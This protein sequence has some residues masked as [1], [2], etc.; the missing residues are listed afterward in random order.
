MP[1]FSAPNATPDPAIWR[2][3][4]NRFIAVLRRTRT[5]TLS[6]RAAGIDA[7]TAYRLR[8]ESPAFRERWDE[9]LAVIDDAAEACLAQRAMQG[10]LEPVYQGGKLVGHVRK[11]SEKLLLAYLKANRPDRFNRAAAEAAK[12]DDG[13]ASKPRRIVFTKRTAPPPQPPP[14]SEA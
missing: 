9:A 4:A 11:W 7:C 3:W 10:W 6:A 13:I 8:E 5:V 12:P 2:P 14:E 1:Q